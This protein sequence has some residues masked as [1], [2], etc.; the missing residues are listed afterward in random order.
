MIVADTHVLIWMMQGSPRLGRHAR[1]AF[2][3]AARDKGVFVSAITPWEIALLVEKRRLFLEREVH[4]WLH[5][6]LDIPGIHLAPLEP[7]LAID[8]VCLPSNFHADPADRMIIATARYWSAPLMTA[9]K[10]ILD[11]ARAGHLRTID[12]A[13]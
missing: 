11:Y 3:Q 13:L 10:A 6:V 1:D 7:S 12:A 2:D 8:S 4:V 9:D 5:D